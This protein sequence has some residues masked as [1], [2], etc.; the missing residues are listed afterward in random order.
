MSNGVVM[1]AVRRVAAVSYITCLLGC[2]M[3]CSFWEGPEGRGRER[4]EEEGQGRCQPAYIYTHTHT[5]HREK[6]RGE[7]LSR[8]RGLARSL[9]SSTANSRQHPPRVY[10]SF[11]LPKLLRPRVDQSRLP[12]PKFR[13][14]FFCRP[15]PPPL[16]CWICNSG[17][18][19]RQTST[20]IITSQ[21]IKIICTF[22][23]IVLP[24]FD[25]F[26]SI[27]VQFSI[28]TKFYGTTVDVKL[29]CVRRNKCSSSTTCFVSFGIAFDMAGL[30]SA[31]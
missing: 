23:L 11:R 7:K 8:Q 31:Y 1:A 19:L 4:P 21:N 6:Q 13:D 25:S 30:V 9:Q 12:S 15:P 28:G 10:T 18:I 20:T 24:K 22:N 5:L 26:L 27:F 29:N 14:Y 2:G 17:Y 16:L 3:L